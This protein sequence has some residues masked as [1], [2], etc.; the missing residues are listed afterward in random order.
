MPKPKKQKDDFVRAV[1]NIVRREGYEKVS[2]NAIGKEL[3]LSSR[4]LYTWYN[5][6]E[7]LKQA[8]LVYAQ[9]YYCQYMKERLQHS[10]DVLFDFMKYYVHF[11]REEKNI[12]KALFFEQ[13]IHLTAQSIFDFHDTAVFDYKW[14][15][16][17]ATRQNDN[18][19]IT[20]KLIFDLWVFIH[21]FS[22]Y[23]LSIVDTVTDTHI[24]QVIESGLKA[25]VPQRYAN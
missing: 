7:E 14:L 20:L 12:F 4:P 25:F 5:N 3:R 23:M 8:F 24:T 21:G 15:I 19:E 2:A 9:Q 10:N 13:F 16:D 22:C 11:V 17:K 1:F 18:C 6:L